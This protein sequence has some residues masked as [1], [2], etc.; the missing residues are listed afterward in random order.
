MRTKSKIYLSQINAS[1]PNDKPIIFWDTCAM[2]DIVRVIERK[3]FDTYKQYQKIIEQIEK[4]NIISITSDLVIVEYTKNLP[5]P[6][7]KLQRSINDL[8]NMVNSTVN[9]IANKR[10]R[11]RVKS[12]SA[13]LHV[14]NNIIGVVER[15][16]ANTI[17]IRDCRELQLRAHKN[18]IQGKAPSANRSQYKDSFIWGV[19]IETIKRVPDDANGN[20]PESAFIS[21]NSK[22]Y[23]EGLNN[24]QPCTA[25]GTECSRYN[26]K[27]HLSLGTLYG[28]LI[29]SGVIIP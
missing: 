1:I 5:E 20:K 2:L 16:W 10:N 8:I 25:L 29:A 17:V 14:E 18:T 15:L 26:G 21:S 22:D 27:L 24:A 4:G 13:L 19:Y 3:S 7:Q 12:A 9:L 6:Q 28:N 11:T 23:G